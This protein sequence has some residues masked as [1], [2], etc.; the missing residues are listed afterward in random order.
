MIEFS[1]AKLT[2]CTVAEV[3]KLNGHFHMED[4]LSR[5]CGM[6]LGVAPD[7][8]VLYYEVS[9]DEDCS[10]DVLKSLID[11]KCRLLK[12]ENIR[13]V[14]FSYSLTNEIQP[15]QYESDCLKLV[16]ELRELKCEVVQTQQ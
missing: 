8:N 2:R 13:V 9:D 1:S 4:V 15:F 14:N 12:G 5:I 3:E 7:S 10:L 6:N 16:E 11:I